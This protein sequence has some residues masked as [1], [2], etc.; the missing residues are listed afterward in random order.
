MIW[1]RQ[2]VDVKP[3]C[4]FMLKFINRNV[5]P[6]SSAAQRK[7]RLDVFDIDSLCVYWLS[8]L[9]TVAWGVIGQHN[10][11]QILLMRLV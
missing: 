4:D 9:L 3:F 11:H 5:V 2:L 8:L 10:F 1:T 7:R 6:K